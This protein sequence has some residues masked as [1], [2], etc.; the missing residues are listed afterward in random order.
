MSFFAYASIIDAILKLVIVY[1]LKIIIYDKLITYSIL[2]V[3]IAVAMFFLYINCI[4]FQNLILVAISIYGINHY[5]KKTFVLLR[6][7]FI[8]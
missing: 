4:A 5:L 6:L 2:I 7:E 3:F 8:W 1:I